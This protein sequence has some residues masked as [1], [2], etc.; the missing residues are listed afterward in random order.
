MIDFRY[1]VASL[2]GIF[3]ALALG[4]LI[5]STLVGQ[6]FLENIT[7][8]QQLWIG[9]LENDYLNLKEETDK[10]KMELKEKNNQLNHYQ[11]F[12]TKIT[13]Y[14]ID[15]KLEGKNFA[16]IDLEQNSH[17]SVEVKKILEQS[18]ALIVSDTKLNFSDG[19]TGNYTVNE[20]I[21][22]T[23]D[24]ILMGEKTELIQLLEGNN[25]IKGVGNYGS[26]IDGII[27][28][29]GSN[30]NQQNKFNEAQNYI[31]NYLK[32]KTSFFV[33]NQEENI[34]TISGP[35]NLIISIFENLNRDLLGNTNKQANLK[36]Q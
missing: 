6:D 7:K 1:H 22:H 2:M 14:L 25:L 31:T 17:L 4:M 33:I 12:I 10:I 8:E 23:L 15:G 34:S 29:N 13:P 27:L 32:G 11:N 5:G 24:L 16:I 18:G 35:V 21:K 36:I 30:T 28:V 19:L 9:K 20:F 3:I 26:P